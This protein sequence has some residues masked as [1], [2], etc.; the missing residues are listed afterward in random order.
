MLTG[1]SGK[2]TNRGISLRFLC[3][4]VWVWPYTAPTY[5]QGN[6]DSARINYI[7]H[8]Q[9]CHRADGSG[10]EGTPNLQAHGRAFLSSPEGR[11][12]FVSVPGVASSSLSDADLTAVINYTIEA[13]IIKTDEAKSLLYTV[14]ELSEYRKTKIVEDLTATRRRVIEG[15]R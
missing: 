1:P 10:G 4:L 6:G 11:D 3:C 7:L 8:C 13:I 14:A 2:A 9:G 15:A 12:Y 5:A